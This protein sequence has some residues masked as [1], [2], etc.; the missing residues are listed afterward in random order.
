MIFRNIQIPS[1][2]CARCRVDEHPEICPLSKITRTT[3][4][5]SSNGGFVPSHQAAIEWI[6]PGG[7]SMYRILNGAINERTR[8]PTALAVPTQKHF[9]MDKAS[10]RSNSLGLY[11]RQIPPAKPQALLAPIPVSSATRFV[12]V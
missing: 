9:S 10:R 3:Q 11:K 2:Q 12:I 7:I 8:H 1:Y 5:E 4:I 6:I